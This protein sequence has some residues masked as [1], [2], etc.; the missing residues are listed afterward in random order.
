MVDS[1]GKL[2]WCPHNI[3]LHSETFDNAWWDKIYGGTGSTPTVTA[4]AGT[5]PDGTETADRIQ[6]DKGAGTA[7]GDYSLV[8]KTS[9]DTDVAQHT[10][11]VFVKSNTGSAQNVMIYCSDL[12][13]VVLEQS[14]GPTWTLMTVTNDSDGKFAIQ[15]GAR[16]S[17]TY[18][19]DDTLD[20][21]V[22]GAHLYRSDLGGMVDNPDRSDSYVPTTTAAVYLPRR[23]H[24]IYDFRT[25]SWV[26]EGV[27]VETDARM[28]LALQSEDLTTTWTKG[29]VTI[30]SAV[31]TIN[32]LSFDRLSV[33]ADVNRHEVFQS[34]GALSDQNYCASVFVK[35]DAAKYAFIHYFSHVSEAFVTAVF[36]LITGTLVET[37]SV[38]ATIALYG[39][40][41]YGSGVYRI[42]VS[43]Q[44][45]G[46]AN[47]YFI[48]GSSNGTGISYS[49]GRPIYLGVTGEDLLFSGAMLEA[50][51]T[52][53]SYIP[54]T[55]ATV[56][57]A[58]E[59][60]H[61]NAASIPY[62]SSTMSWSL[63]F[64]LIYADTGSA[65]EQTLYDWSVDSDNRIAVTLDTSGADRD[66][67]TLTVVNAASSV[68]VSTTVE[69]TPGINQAAKIAWRVTTSEIN[70]ALNG[71]AETAVSNTAGIPGLAAAD[72]AL[73]DMVVIGERR[74]WDADLGDLGIEG[75]ST[76]EA[77]ELF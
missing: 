73:G 71:T 43:G 61:E 30:D 8:G 40:E 77:L 46:G 48:F 5:A 53:S 2:K 26:N 12:S 35:D 42:F 16:D 37:N 41:D 23:G 25:S 75:A 64:N 44:T 65:T 39:I 34:V 49:K 6:F 24:H 67:I 72:A 45:G 63:D 13:V 15:I 22:W 51:A 54:T 14:I 69:R 31:E 17:A 4:K 68:S 29:A 38:G 60:L 36:D 62:S 1:D 11:S 59:T 70:I 47:G 19:G 10:F 66:V 18:G 56:T 21:L 28:N 76:D 20:I 50:G 33:D 27:L 3:A 9:I 55:S 74:Q 7:S 32:G 58:A 57:R 52:P